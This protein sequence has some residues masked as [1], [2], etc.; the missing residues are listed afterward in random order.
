MLKGKRKFLIF[1]LCALVAAAV[2]GFVITQ[3][4]VEPKLFHRA[5]GKSAAARPSIVDQTAYRTALG[6]QPLASTEDEQ[7]LAL[8]AIH[9][10]DREV[11]IAFAS[12]LSRAKAA[13]PVQTKDTAEINRRLK[14]LQSRLQ[15]E[16]AE[17]ERLT[18]L[19]ANPGKYDAT[20][21]HQQ[22]EIGQAQISVLQDAIDDA[23]E[24][25]VRAG[26]D[27]EAVI[28]EEL[29]EHESLQHGS[30]AAPAPPHSKPETL[31]VEGNL[32]GQFR[33]WQRLRQSQAQLLQ[34][35]LQANNAVDT[36]TKKHEALEKGLSGSIELG[37]TVA[38]ENTTPDTPA[39]DQTQHADKLAKLNKLSQNTK[40]LSAYD[41]RIDLEKQLAEIYGDWAAIVNAQTRLALHAILR[42]LLWILLALLGL[43]IAEGAIEHFFLSLGPDRRKLGTTRLALR[44]VS[45]MIGV[46]II[47]LVLFGP[48]SQ[49]STILA[50]AGAGLTVALKDFIVAFFGWFVLMGHNGIRVGDWVEINGIGGEVL[51]IGLLRTI[52]LETGNW[53]DA[54]HPT[55]RRVSFV[56]SFAVEGHYFN[57]TTAGQ[58]LWDELDIL[59]PAAEDPYELTKSVLRLVTEQT[60]NE[61]AL[62]EKEWQRV[63]HNSAVQSFSAAPAIN[64]RPTNLGVNLVVRYVANAHS[65]Y[66]VRTRLYEAIVEL[67]HSQKQARSTAGS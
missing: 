2:V 29:E 55:G 13:P 4:G 1:G 56:N 30:S 45:Q 32:L 51:E 54:G 27:P 11:D 47:L 60:H 5:T 25:L 19:V 22:L 53:N 26:G 58:W 52:L 65:R 33:A 41:K 61:A 21:I 10:S 9:I 48:P 8:E 36:L 46:L 50:L 62:A 7:E 38:D 16:Q 34:A 20:V 15:S 12:A 17:V 37:D 28:Q 64:V 67:M 43:V 35:R 66:E 63:T 6:L 44:F 57:F 59:I 3:Q 24:D 23:K 42:S 40:I 49:L 31:E 39:A 18:K 14:L